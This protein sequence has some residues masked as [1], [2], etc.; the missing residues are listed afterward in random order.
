MSN[1]KNYPLEPGLNYSDEQLKAIYLEGNNILVSAAAGSGKTKVLVERI[2]KE[3]ECGI[4]DINE[5][6]VMTFTRAATAD[7]KDKIKKRIDERLKFLK[8]SYDEKDKKDRIRRLKNQ[9]LFIQNANVS[10]IDSFCKR[11]DQT[12]R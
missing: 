6:L 7:M 2:V 9:S 4:C 3:L 1:I 12:L 8:S 11:L 10:T 5:M